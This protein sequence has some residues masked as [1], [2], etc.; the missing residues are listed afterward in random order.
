MIAERKK[1]RLLILKNPAT[2]IGVEIA[3]FSLILFDYGW[4]TENKAEISEFLDSCCDGWKISGM[5]LQFVS[6]IDMEMFL[7]RYGN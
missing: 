7:L 5:V 6:E 4:W 2:S 1:E 3:P